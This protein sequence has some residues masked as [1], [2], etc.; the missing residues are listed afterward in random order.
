MSFIK[1][2][3]NAYKS[4]KIATLAP[5]RGFSSPPSTMVDS[6]IDLAILWTQKSLE[7][8]QVQIMA[9]FFKESI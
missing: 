7:N 6:L 9:S 2:N 8:P 4:N 5:Y 1:K 3:K